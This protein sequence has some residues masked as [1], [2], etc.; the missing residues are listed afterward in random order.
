MEE[1]P[2]NSLGYWLFYAQRSWAY[3][4]NE[5]LKTCCQEHGKSYAVTP[6]QWGVLSAL[7]EEDGL[8]IGVL[9]QR[10]ALDAPTITG[11]VKR[12][13]QVELV[14]RVHGREDRRVV[15][16]FLTE[17]GHDLMSFLPDAV[18]AFSRVA[19]QGISVEK[20]QELCLLMQQT[21]ANLSTIGPGMGDRFGLLPDFLRSD[22]EQQL[23]DD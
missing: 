15:R 21:I 23:C 9:S 22:L 1:R 5:A 14:E 12:L 16:V 13:E 11:I 20:Q 10:R 3:A 18:V 19:L 7:L 4:F 2:E 17:E 8:T 6:P